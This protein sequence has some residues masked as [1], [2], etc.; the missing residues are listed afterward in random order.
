MK[1]K[2]LQNYHLLLV[3]SRLDE[4]EQK[5]FY[6]FSVYFGKLLSLE[7]SYLNWLVLK[8]RPIRKQLTLSFGLN[9]DYIKSEISTDT[10]NFL[11]LF[12]F[13]NYAQNL[14]FKTEYLGGV[15][16]RQVVF[17]VR[18]F[19]EFQNPM[20]TSTNHYQLEKIKNFL[21]Q[22]QTGLFITSFNDTY[23]QSLVA[24]PQVRLNKCPK[25]KYWIGKVWLV[26]EFFY[27]S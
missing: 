24:I 27:H 11:M 15:A 23:F 21:Q 22:L 14:N 1:G 8:L 16:Y 6:H 10:T 2:F 26:E 13:L 17:K 18:D 5:F 19:L 12:Q 7:F 3:S 9:S 25:Q 4:F 20:V